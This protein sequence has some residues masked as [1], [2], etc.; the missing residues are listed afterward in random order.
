MS[1][2]LLHFRILRQGRSLSLESADSARLLAQQ[3]PVILLFLPPSFGVFMWV[4]G[5][6][7]EQ[8]VPDFTDWSISQAHFF[9]LSFFYMTR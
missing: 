2:A 9:F 8:H 4:S 5:I 3:A 7:L 6:A 1:V